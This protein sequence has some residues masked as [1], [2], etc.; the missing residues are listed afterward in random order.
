MMRRV[1]VHHLNCATMCPPAG[2]LLNRQG[3]TIAHC[4]AIEAPRGVVLVDTGLGLDDCDAPRPRLG[5]QFLLLVAPELLRGESAVEQLARRGIDRREVRDI[6]VTHLDP[7]HAGGLSDFPEATVH[8]LERERRG[9]VGPLPFPHSR[10]YRRPH[11]SHGPKWKDYTADGEKWFGM[12]SV[13]AVEGVGA[14]ILLVPLP[15]HTL[16]HAGVAVNTSNGWLLHAGDAYFHKDELEGGSGSFMLRLF[17]RINA[18]D[19]EQRNANLARLVELQRAGSVKVFS[20]H[21]P[22]EYDHFA[23]TIHHG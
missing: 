1:R 17:Q 4:L 6:V 16:G 7:D 8:V 11:F 19:W 21:D 22:D 20:S 18:M 23:K 13:R 12:P 10:R 5:L 9:L 14:E 2:G 3:K 15:G